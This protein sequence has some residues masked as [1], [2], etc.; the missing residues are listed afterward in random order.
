MKT[1]AIEEH[2]STDQ[3]M[4][5]SQAIL[6][7]TY[8]VPKVIGEEKAIASEIIWLSTPF[9]DKLLNVGEGRLREMDEAGIDMQVLSLVQPD[10]Q[11]FDADTGTALAK[12]INDRL[13]EVVRVNN[14]RFAGFATIAPQDPKAAADPAELIQY[15]N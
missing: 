15:V 1:I 12:K 11:A 13:S 14:K 7:K 9:S 6:E 3:H 2:F 5:F 10:V 8:P 4:D